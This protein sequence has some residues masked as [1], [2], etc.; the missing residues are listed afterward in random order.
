MLRHTFTLIFYLLSL[1]SY[2][3]LSFAARVPGYSTDL[4]ITRNAI[5]RTKPPR[6]E[7]IVY[8][9]IVEYE[10]DVSTFSNEQLVGLVHQGT[11]T[12]SVSV[13]RFKLT[14]HI[15]VGGN[16]SAASELGKS[17]QGR[18]TEFCLIS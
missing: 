10:D 4:G 2:L 12:F 13:R 14:H 9:S 6:T 7:F 1:I 11:C 17:V 18:P 5:T 16:E 3:H 15:S 8:T